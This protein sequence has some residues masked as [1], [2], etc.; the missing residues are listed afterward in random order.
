MS[1]CFCEKLKEK[2]HAVLVSETRSLSEQ[3]LQAQSANLPLLS[4]LLP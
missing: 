1:I 2:K 4:L 3:N